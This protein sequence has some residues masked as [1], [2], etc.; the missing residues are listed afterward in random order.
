M[1]RVTAVFSKII[2]PSCS[3]TSASPRTSRAGSMRAQCGEYVRAERA[4]HASVRGEVRIVDPREVVGADP[5][6]AGR[7]DLVEQS[8][9]LDLAAR[10]RHRA[11]VDESRVD[12]VARGRRTEFDDGVLEHVALMVERLAAVAPDDAGVAQRKESRGPAAVATGRAE[13]ADLFLEHRDAKATRHVEAVRA[14]STVR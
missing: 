12:A 9:A 11:A 1:I 5:I 13:A 10:E 3:S 8:R 2:A 4:S 6:V 14:R 7:G